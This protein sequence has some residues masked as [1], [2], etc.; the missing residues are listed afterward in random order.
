MSTIK[1]REIV[2]H[3]ILPHEIRISELGNIER[4]GLAT[5]DPSVSMAHWANIYMRSEVIGVQAANTILTKK[6]ELI[7]FMDWFFKENGILDIKDWLP[8]DTKAYMDDL[9]KRGFSPYTVNR[10]FAVIRHFAR[11]VQNQPNNPFMAGLPTKGIKELFIEEP[12][13]KHLET[14]EVNRL[15]KAADRLVVTETR[16]NSHSRRNRAILALLYYTGLRVSELCTLHADQY[17]GKHLLN[18]QRKGR[19]RTAKLYL[20]KDC[21]TYLDDYRGHVQGGE[22]AYLIAGKNADP[23]TRLTVWRVLCKLANEASA[24]HTDKLKIHPHQL[25]HTFGYEV[26]KRTGS[27]TETAALLGHS[28]LNYVGRYV[29]RTDAEREEILD[30][31]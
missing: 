21:R 11:W 18:V 27:D 16:K 26:R 3:N 29:R 9:E 4:L 25:R 28:G 5:W 30:D 13:A 10:A 15:F 2:K 12:P 24:H 7:R 19:S 23:I 8:R 22:N 6:Y 31:L 20:S 1:N 14:R 17:D